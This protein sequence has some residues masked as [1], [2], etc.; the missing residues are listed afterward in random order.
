MRSIGKKRVGIPHSGTA[1]ALMKPQCTRFSSEP[2]AI[3]YANVVAIKGMDDLLRLVCF[4][5][6]DFAR[7]RPR[8]YSPGAL[9]LHSSGL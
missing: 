2:K 6:L 7:L 9:N 1:E 3:V 5:L 4:S 8:L